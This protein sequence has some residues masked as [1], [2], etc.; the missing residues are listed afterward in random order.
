MLMA[1]LF[2]VFLCPHSADAFQDK[3]SFFEPGG[4]CLDLC[5]CSDRGGQHECA[6][7]ELHPYQ[8][9]S[10]T[11]KLSGMNLDDLIWVCTDFTSDDARQEV[12]WACETDIPCAFTYTVR[13]LDTIILRV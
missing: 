12:A 2:C 4:T 1:V 5:A 11:S 8:F 7:V 3:C 13:H 9:L 6:L 10:E